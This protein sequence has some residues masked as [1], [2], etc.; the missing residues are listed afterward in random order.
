MNDLAIID[1]PAG[2][3]TTLATEDG[4]LVLVD[5]ETGEAYPLTPQA[6]GRDLAA[7]LSCMDTW[8][9]KATDTQLALFMRLLDELVSRVQHAKVHAGNEAIRRMDRRTLWTMPT[10]Y[11]KLTAPS[12]SRVTEYHG[13]PLY[14]A[15]T[16]LVAE[17]VIEPEARDGAVE[18]RESVT[19]HPKVGGI[20]RL[21]KLGNERI[22][23]AIEANRV[24][25]ERGD[26]R[27]TI[28]AA[29]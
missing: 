24:E 23:A 14:E 26:R 28:R 19:Y 4:S 11:G 2:T 6:T 27:V 16:E 29:S 5:T 25:R 9:P 1:Q 15:L 18:K 12:P 13:R 8:L 20:S 21:Q 22:D 17:G 10:P 3:L 7:F